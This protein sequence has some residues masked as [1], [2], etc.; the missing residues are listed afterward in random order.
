MPKARN[1]NI[2]PSKN[3]SFSIFSSVFPFS[4]PPLPSPLNHSPLPVSLMNMDAG[5]VLRLGGAGETCIPTSDRRCWQQEFFS[6]IRSESTSPREPSLTLSLSETS[7][8]QLPAE[9]SSSSPPLSS[10]VKKETDEAVSEDT[11]K[12]SPRGSDEEEYGSARKKL[13]LSKEQSALLE[14][15]FKEQSTL[16]PKQKQAL[17]KQLK[18]RPRQVEVWFQNRRART[19]VKQTEVDCELLRRFCESLTNENRR[20]HRELQDLKA[21]KLASPAPLYVQIPA[22]ATLTVCPSCEKAAAG[23]GAKVGA[24]SPATTN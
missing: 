12:V 18:L 13:R 8:W 17:A 7:Y 10:A 5:L 15:R 22:A 23:D 11:E 24:F 16:N 21:L 20:L 9:G 1:L 3:L 19:K 4:S 6:S 2:N 14:D